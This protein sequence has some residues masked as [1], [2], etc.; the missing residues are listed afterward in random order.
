ML[1]EDDLALMMSERFDQMAYARDADAPMRAVPHGQL[2][3]LLGRESEVARIRELLTT[4][5]VRLVTVVGSGGA[6]KT[7]IA[8]ELINDAAPAFADGVWFVDLSTVREPDDVL[9]TIAKVL[10]VREQPGKPIGERLARVL[11]DRKALVVLDNF[12]QVIDA[13][14][15]VVSLLQSTR[16]LS[17]L[18]TSRSPLRVGGERTVEV[19]PLPPD[20]AY[21][22]FLERA[23]A[24]RTDA[25]EL[26]RRGRGG[27]RDLP[28]AGPPSPRNR[29]RGRPDGLAHGVGASRS[30]R[31][32]TSRDRGPAAG[33]SCAPANSP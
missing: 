28:E 13:A 15:D 21:A 22:L 27:W 7:R 20:A 23:R 9:G 10:G 11:N 32:H 17:M 5:G 6:G 25:V 16:G 33:P 19:G 8:L 2:T 18:I 4:A 24:V 29:A 1:L 14:V 3:T 26:R 30:D 31:A 12:E